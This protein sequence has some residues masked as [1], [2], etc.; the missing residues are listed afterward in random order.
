MA[1]FIEAIQE[2]TQRIQSVLCVGLD[3]SLAKTPDVL[4]SDA[5]PQLAWNRAI[6]DATHDL[7]CCYKPNLA[8]YLIYGSEGL[9]TLKE[10][11]RY[12]HSYNVPV[13]LDAKFGDIGHTALHYARSAFEALEADSVTLNPYMGEES[14]AP[15]RK[16]SDRCSFILCLTSNVSRLDFQTLNTPNDDLMEKPLFHRVAEK[17]GEWN[18]NRNLAAVVGATA[19]EELSQV[20]EFLGD[21]MP[22]LCPGVG[23]QGGDL[24]EVLWAGHAGPGTLLINVSRTIINASADPDFA[25]A[26]RRE[27]TMFVNQIR[28]FLT[29]YQEGV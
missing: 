20:R 21:E 11:I 23:A 15:F 1:S 12:A 29:Q 27:A 7:A 25:E 4:Q 16:Y 5:N 6:I 2:R 10:T 18:T 26:S 3:T 22:I 8:F 14:I 9:E 24:E 28:T 17:I 13:I 19:P